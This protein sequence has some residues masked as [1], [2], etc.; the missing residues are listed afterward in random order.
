MK[1]IFLDVDGVLNSE[2]WYVKNHKRH[3]ERCRADNAINPRFVRNLAKIVRK[4]GA[5]IV[6][7]ATCRGSV[8]V[9]LKHYLRKILKQYGLEIYDY[10]P[11]T[12]M[13]RGI[14]IQEWLNHNRDVT[15]IVIID[16]DS[17]MMHLM[18]YLVKTHAHPAIKI[19]EK[20]YRFPIPFIWFFREGLT[21]YKARQA[22]KMLKKPFINK[23]AK[24]VTGNIRALF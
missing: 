12:G 6:L 21:G 5:K 19:K 20:W 11:R 16:D 9:N 22:I 15:N 17:D 13:E 8:A 10:T 4:T 3:P 18:E 24:Q 7:S 14:D 2:H 1:V 23:M